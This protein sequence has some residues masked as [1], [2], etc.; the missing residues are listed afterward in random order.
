MTNQLKQQYLER[1]RMQSSYP[2]FRS[3][4]MIF[5]YL[6]Y[7]LAGIIA[8]FG[9]ILGLVAMFNQGFFPGL[10]LILG[11]V[12]TAAIYF[13]IGKVFK[14]AAS[15]LADVVDSITDFYSRYEQQPPQ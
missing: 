8:F 14:E 3:L 6:L 12:V 2:A 4:I 9:L 11:A 15:M 13:V 5:T 10:G 1:I 7:I